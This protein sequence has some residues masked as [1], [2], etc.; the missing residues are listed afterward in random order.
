MFRN[1]L[2]DKRHVNHMFNL[3]MCNETVPSLLNQLVVSD[4]HQEF[5]WYTPLT[6]CIGSYCKNTLGYDGYEEST[7]LFV[8]MAR[9]CMEPTNNVLFQTCLELIKIASEQQRRMYIHEPSR[10]HVLHVLLDFSQS[11]CGR[12][13][14]LQLLRCYFSNTVQMN[15]RNKRWLL[16]SKNFFGNSAQQM[17]HELNQ[18]TLDDECRRWF[19]EYTSSAAASTFGS[20]DRLLPIINQVDA[21]ILEKSNGIVR[22]PIKCILPIDN[23][24]NEFIC[25]AQL[26][27]IDSKQPDV[28]NVL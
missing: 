16:T 15:T 7:L 4:H 25:L 8:S 11:Q 1:A 28:D 17:L 24:V 20:I 14:W 9:L 5:N 18:P 19:P 26:F 23:L 27:Q 13:K 6:N 10:S 3:L 12:L 2:N 22:I 21:D